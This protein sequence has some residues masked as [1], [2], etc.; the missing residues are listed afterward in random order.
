MLGD[1][2]RHFFLQ[3][4][5]LTSEPYNRVNMPV[6]TGFTPLSGDSP[7][8]LLMSWKHWLD[9]DMIVILTMFIV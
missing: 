4:W 6:G 8:L 1:P 7:G 9:V 2:L 3:C 5:A